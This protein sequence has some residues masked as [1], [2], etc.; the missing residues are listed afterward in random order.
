MLS[1]EKKVIVTTTHGVRRTYKVTAVNVQRL[2]DDLRHY[3]LEIPQNE[4]IVDRT[5][6]MV[7]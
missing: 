4:A 7:L 3:R 6:S 5:R 1:G 2:L